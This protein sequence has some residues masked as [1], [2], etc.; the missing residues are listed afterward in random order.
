[1][2]ITIEDFGPIK[3][4]EYDLDKDFIVTYGNNNI[5]K[6]YAMQI[7]YLLLKTFIKSIPSTQTGDYSYYHIQIP[8]DE[9]KLLKKKFVYIYDEFVQSE[10]D[11]RDITDLYTDSLY[12]HFAKVF[13]DVFINACKNTFGNLD[14]IL[15]GNPRIYYSDE[16]YSFV[17]LL[18]EHKING[19]TEKQ[20]KVTLC[21]KS[22]EAHGSL[23]TFGPLENM[24]YADQFE[25]YVYPSSEKEKIADRFI[26]EGKVALSDW[27]K[28]IKNKFDDVYF[29][30][31]LKSGIYIGMSAFGSIVAD[32]SK[33]RAFINKKIELPGISEPISDY[34]IA[35]STI[36]SSL[37]V[38]YEKYYS[39][40]EKDILKGIVT[41]DNHKN[42][43]IYK[44]KD[45]ELQFEMTEVSSMVS[46]IAPIVAFMKYV[47]NSQSGS[48]NEKRGKAI[49]FIEEPEAH[50]HPNN[51]IALMEVFAELVQAN[52]KLIMSSHSNYVFVK[53]NNMVLSKQLDYQRYQPIILNE[54]SEGSASKKLKIDE[55]GAWD[56]NFTDVSERLYEEREEIIEKLNTG[57][58]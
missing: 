6:S 26:P 42:K 50:L 54:T 7:V 33:N 3:K 57:E 15:N 17:I 28:H 56:E 25:I 5:G 27:N 55:L 46:E 14:N 23:S 38:K 35:L 43:L 53:L 20:R 58:E 9:R 45:L 24:T 16:I 44:P 22:V 48:A 51:Q 39:K 37:N 19:K 12:I 18:K 36:K 31:A 4:F 49:L 34:F 47:L 13:I 40:I 29:L 10:Q 1:M 21:K 41:Y 32:L 8:D 11:E 2:K 30:P 52:V